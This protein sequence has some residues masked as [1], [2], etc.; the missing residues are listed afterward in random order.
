MNQN[1]ASK[2]KATGIELGK[3]EL[4]AHELGHALGLS[5]EDD[6][7]NLMHRSSG[8]TYW[9]FPYENNLTAKQC[10]DARNRAIANYS[11]I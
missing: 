11:A 9:F 8:S 5:H 10:S 3:P 4:M 1:W 2:Q 6:L 7:D